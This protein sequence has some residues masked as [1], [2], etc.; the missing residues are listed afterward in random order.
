VFCPFLNQHAAGDEA[1]ILMFLFGCVN[2][3]FVHELTL[4]EEG[5]VE[6]W[7]EKPN[8]LSA[9]AILPASDKQCQCYF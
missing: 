4:R 2:E 5:Q 1:V 3:A 8:G 7:V 9:S 6:L